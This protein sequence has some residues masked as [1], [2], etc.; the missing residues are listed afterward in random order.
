[1]WTLD[2][3]INSSMRRHN[4]YCTMFISHWVPNMCPFFVFAIAFATLV[5][6][7]TLA[8][9]IITLGRLCLVS[10]NHTLCEHAMA[11]TSDT[12]TRPHNSSPS[13]IR[14]QEVPEIVNGRFTKWI[15]NLQIW[16][17][18]HLCN[19][20]AARVSVPNAPF[21]LSVTAEACIA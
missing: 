5:I 10:R 20:K 19:H 1:M 3:S 21:K 12:H 8:E 2:A 17:C 14:C 11:Q 9:S 4:C 15:L 7:K 13:G 16:Q 6:M 18:F